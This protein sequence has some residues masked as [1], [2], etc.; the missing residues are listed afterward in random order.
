M[1]TGTRN[2]PP[3]TVEQV[4]ALAR[5]QGEI[6]VNPLKWKKDRVTDACFRAAKL[7]LLRKKR[8]KPDW[9]NFYPVD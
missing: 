8:I 5:K 3:M 7:G 9:I 6:Q 2:K 4:V 1:P